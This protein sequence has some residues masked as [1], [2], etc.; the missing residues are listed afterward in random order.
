MLKTALLTLILLLPGCVC[1]HEPAIT[2]DD[3]SA[4]ETA[5]SGTVFI[6][7]DP[8]IS[9]AVYEGEQLIISKG[10]VCDYGE[11]RIE[12]NATT[13]IMQIDGCVVEGFNSAFDLRLYIW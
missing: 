10:A 9:G 12:G 8:M 7:Y 1:N 11:M 2:C 6:V 13:G 5:T 4:E 3:D